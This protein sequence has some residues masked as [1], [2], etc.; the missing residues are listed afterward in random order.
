MT[1]TVLVLLLWGGELDEVGKSL[2]TK[3]P[4][5]GM[6]SRSYMFRRMTVKTLHSV[7]DTVCECGIFM[8]V[9]VFL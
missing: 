3:V 4:T 6:H 7:S 5:P 8:K 9:M 2:I 1:T